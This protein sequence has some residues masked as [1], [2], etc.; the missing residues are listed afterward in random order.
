MALRQPCSSFFGA[1]PTPAAQALPELCEHLGVDLRSPAAALV[2][3]EE[4]VQ[5][6]LTHEAH[7]RADAGTGAAHSGGDL[8]EGML[9]RKAEAHGLEPL[10]MTLGTTCTEAS[11]HLGEEV[12]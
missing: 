10:Q 7:P 5:A 8:R 1:F 3:T 11:L 6:L 4:R 12:W 2:A 9:A